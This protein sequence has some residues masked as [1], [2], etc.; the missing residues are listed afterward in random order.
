[1][2]QYSLHPLQYLSEVEVFAGDIV[3]RY[4]P[5]SKRQRE[6]SVTMKEKFDRDV[7]FIID[8]IVKEDEN[9]A[10]SEESLPRSMACLAVAISEERPRRKVGSLH[11]F[12]YVAAVVCLKELENFEKDGLYSMMAPSLVGKNQVDTIRDGWGTFTMNR[13]RETLD[14][15]SVA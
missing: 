10:R 12:G 3:G 15:V 2:S 11:S 4:G 13:L 14:S 1:M 8:C 5:Q 7:A 9:G 6:A